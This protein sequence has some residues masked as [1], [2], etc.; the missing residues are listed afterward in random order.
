VFAVGAPTTRNKLDQVMITSPDAETRVEA[1]PPVN[2][3]ELENAVS[4]TAGWEGKRDGRSNPANFKRCPSC[5][6][7]LNSCHRCKGE[8]K[9]PT[10]HPSWQGIADAPS[11][12]VLVDR[13]KRREAVEH[14]KPER[15]VPGL[16]GVMFEAGPPTYSA[17]VGRHGELVNRAGEPIRVSDARHNVVI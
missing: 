17:F 6:V 14:T 16:E 12:A 7:R 15:N 1:H 13:D 10:D 11:E 5:N 3:A 4:A 8:Q 9:K 2:P